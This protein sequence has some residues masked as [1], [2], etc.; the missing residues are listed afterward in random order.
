MPLSFLGSLAWIVCLTASSLTLPV[1]VGGAVALIVKELP[2]AERSMGGTSQANDSAG[3]VWRSNPS[4]ETIES[5]WY[6]D[7]C[8]EEK[9]GEIHSKIMSCH[10]KIDRTVGSATNH[11]RT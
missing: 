10:K 11:E 4:N 1:E 7:V 2:I 9:L 8:W 5:E 3:E 6:D